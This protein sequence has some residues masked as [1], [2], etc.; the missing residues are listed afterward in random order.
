MR[1]ASRFNPIPYNRRVAVQITLT[2][3]YRWSTFRKSL[4]ASL[5]QARDEAQNPK[6]REVLGKWIDYLHF[7]QRSPERLFR[8]S[9]FATAL[10][11]GTTDMESDQRGVAGAHR[12][13]LVAVEGALAGN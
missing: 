3:L 8:D 13:V 12:A 7:K 5:V 10:L 4:H 6:E 9:F 11:L 2:R 1:L